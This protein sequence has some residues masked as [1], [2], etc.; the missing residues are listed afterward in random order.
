MTRDTDRASDPW[1]RRRSGERTPAEYRQRAEECRQMAARAFYPE[2]RA[3]FLQVAQSYDELAEL[4][5]RR[6]ASRKGGLV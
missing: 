5:E 6:D 4:A 2:A 3:T 1:Q